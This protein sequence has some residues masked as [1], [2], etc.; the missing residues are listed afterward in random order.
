MQINNF[1]LVERIKELD[2]FYNPD[3]Y[4]VDDIGIS[5]L[6]ADVNTGKALYNTT[7]ESWFVYDG[8]KWEKDELDL[9]VDAYAKDFALAY[10][11]YLEEQESIINNKKLSTKERS[12]EMKRLKKNMVYCMSLGARAHRKTII[13]DA[14]SYVPVSQG[15][16]DKQPNLFNCLN[17]VLDLNTGKFLR[18]SSDLLLSKV[19]NVEYDPT[20]KCPRFIQFMKDIMIHNT[21]KI[22]Y[23]Q[24]LF[25]YAM[26]G[27]NEQ[28]EAYIL[29]GSTTRNG[30]STLLDTMNSLFGDYGLNIQPES[31]SEQK[32]N[33]RAAS[34]DVARLDGCRLLQM[35][36]PPKSMKLDVAMLKTLTGRDTI[37]AR[38]LYENE[39]EFTPIFKLFINANYLPVVIDDTLFTSER[40]KVITFDRHFEPDEQDK[41]L[42]DELKTPESLSGI[43]NW[44][45]SGNRMY[46][47]DP[48]AIKPP[49]SVRK[50]TDEYRA[51][52]DKMMLFLNDIGSE[53]ISSTYSCKDLYEQYI[54]WCRENNFG[55]DGKISFM[56]KLREMPGF[57]ERATIEGRTVRNVFSFDKAG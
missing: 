51:H 37:T 50:A 7:A 55:G 34:G 9:K 3:I 27:T 56:N 47:D 54:L 4:S 35:A 17:G 30:K 22:K 36:E 19:A 23:L 10:L 20:A 42:K 15:D 38:R 6:F 40:I 44:I 49:E 28:E 11:I 32:K 21:E 48:E 16:F 52:S 2:P 41:G 26:S 25:G 18:H 14:R 12:D 24:V 46:R 39:F 1:E 8:I 53:G 57:K 31:L 13:E 29:Y 43:L 5:R 33:G 45:I